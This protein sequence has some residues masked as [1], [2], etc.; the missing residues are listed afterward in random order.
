[1]T[2]YMS[3]TKAMIRSMKMSNFLAPLLR[4]GLVK[5]RL[6]KTI[7]QREAGPDER[8]RMRGAALIW[9]EVRNESG[10]VKTAVFKTAEGYRLT[11]EMA[12]SIAGKVQSGFLKEGYQTPS[13]VYSE[14][15]IFEHPDTVWLKKP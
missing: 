3:A 11:A 5:K 14:N 2:V 8:S 12:W 1:V 6:G 10:E 13:S 15:L 7:E 4:L 9:G